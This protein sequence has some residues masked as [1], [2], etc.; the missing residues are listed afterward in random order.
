M[1]FQ[2]Q[3]SELVCSQSIDIELS[4]DGKTV[5]SVAFTGGCPG[6]LGGIAKLVAG[7]DTDRVIAL[8]AGQTCGGKPTSCPDQLATALK[9]A[10]QKISAAR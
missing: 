6:N 7:M 1:K 10:K 4:D 5:R 8:L 3:T 2:Y 9:L